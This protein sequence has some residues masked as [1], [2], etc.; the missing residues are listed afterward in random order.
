MKKPQL[1]TVRS[2][3]KSGLPLSILALV[4]ILS[5]ASNCLSQER[6]SVTSNTT[7]LPVNQLVAT[8]QLGFNFFP[9]AV[10]VSPDSKTVY[11]SSSSP[12]GGMLSVIDTQS[13][14]ITDTIS[15][16]GL[17]TSLVIS[18][19]GT[20]L[21][22]GNIRT[23]NPPANSS[24][25]VV[26]TATKATTAT[27]RMPGPDDLAISPNGKKIYATDTIRKAI[28]IIN[29]TT[30]NVTRDAI[31]AGGA[32][33]QIA[34]SRDGKYVYTSNSGGPVS[35][36]DLG[37]KQVVA[38]ISLNNNGA[39]VYFATSPDG[40]TLYINT[41]KDVLFADTS[42]NTIVHTTFMPVPGP[43]NFVGGQPG[44]TS[45]GNFLYVP[46]PFG[47]I[48]MV[49][50]VTKKAAGNQISVGDPQA[51]AVAPTANFAYAVGDTTS[52]NGEE[53]ELY[54]INISPE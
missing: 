20:T 22:V 14:S 5:S 30:N 40:T 32:C 52:G 21:Y 4:F 50:T 51:V 25:T 15:V 37:T 35:V 13:N 17:P 41:R 24:V 19:D 1:S 9:V 3:A 26:S 42:T 45:D 12:N 28:S 8:V 6:A 10:V 16:P 31:N 54:V 23:V 44:I 38:T 33:E 43:Y 36:I 53:G 49:D 48:V 2:E 7:T 29:T 27:I 11:V 34:V 18:P 46:F 39:S 47:P